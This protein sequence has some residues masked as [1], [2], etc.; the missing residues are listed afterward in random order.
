[1]FRKICAIFTQDLTY[2]QEKE[3]EEALYHGLSDRQIAFLSRQGWNHEKMHEARLCL[4]DGIPIKQI[5]KLMRLETDEIR[6]KRKQIE[7]GE[8]VELKS[9]RWET[10]S[11]CMVSIGVICL[12]LSGFIQSRNK[13]YLHLKTDSVLLKKGETFDPMSYVESYSSSHRRLYLPEA[14]NTSKEGSYMVVYKLVHGNQ[15]II[16]S[17]KIQVTD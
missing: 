5:K 4:Q 7:R 16:A 6:T 11:M 17:M 14:V 3:L 10:L 13:P 2:L 9:F 15:E 1:M 8:I 12:L